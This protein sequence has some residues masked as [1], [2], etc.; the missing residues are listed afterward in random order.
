MTASIQQFLDLESE[1]GEKFIMLLHLLISKFPSKCG[2]IFRK[3]RSRFCILSTMGL[4]TIFFFYFFLFH[5][6]KVL[7]LQMTNKLKCFQMLFLRVGIY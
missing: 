2:V 4:L 5:F 3:L 7:H 1:E 6:I